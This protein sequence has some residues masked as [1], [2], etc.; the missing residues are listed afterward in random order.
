[1]ENEGETQ[2]TP[3][4]TAFS[5]FKYCSGERQ[6]MLI[7]F[8]E[9]A[10]AFG[11]A[12]LTELN[13]NYVNKRINKTFSIASQHEIRYDEWS[14]HRD[15]VMNFLDRCFQTD[16]LNITTTT[17]ILNSLCKMKCKI[18]D[19]PISIYA[20]FWRLLD[21]HFTSNERIPS[22]IALTLNGFANLGQLWHNLPIDSNSVLSQACL[23]EA[24]RRNHLFFDPK[25]TA[26]T[27]H[28]FAK[29]G[30]LWN[31]LPIDIGEG[32]LEAVRQNHENFSAESCAMVFLRFG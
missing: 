20:K 13:Q 23:F 8:V 14:D 22:Y 19:L 15:I 26:L 29:M 21:A 16:V 5:E 18:I 30:L 7:K 25:D 3:Y 24:V 6:E 4:E 11:G 27:W 1:M 12:D 31:D 2:S 32:I 17:S 9:V 28:A 10:N